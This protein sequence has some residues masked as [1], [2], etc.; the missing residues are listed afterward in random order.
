MIIEK[1]Y[2]IEMKT[3]QFETLCDAIEL[4]EYDFEYRITKNKAYLTIEEYELE[5]ILGDFES[6]LT[7]ENNMIE[8]CEDEYCDIKDLYYELNNYVY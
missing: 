1:L 5:E 4:E 7:D 8:E 3:K 6:Y 2:K